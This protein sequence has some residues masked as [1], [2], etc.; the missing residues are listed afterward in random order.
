MTASRAPARA[1][2]P[3]MVADYEQGSDAHGILH[4]LAALVN[5]DAD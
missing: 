1:D 5:D 2:W 3:A 4:K